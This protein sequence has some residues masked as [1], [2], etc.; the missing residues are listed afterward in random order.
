MMIKQNTNWGIHGPFFRYNMCLSILI[1]I[2][3]IIFIISGLRPIFCP[4]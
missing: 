3:I 1:L 2:V 4:S